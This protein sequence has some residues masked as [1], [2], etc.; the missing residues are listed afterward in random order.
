MLNLDNQIDFQVKSGD[1]FIVDTKI[2]VSYM[3]KKDLIFKCQVLEKI[4]FQTLLKN[5]DI[6]L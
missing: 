1:E 5:T 6:H 4:K 2:S 3:K